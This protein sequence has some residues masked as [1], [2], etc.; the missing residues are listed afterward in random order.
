MSVGHLVIFRYLSRE[1][2]VISAA[3]TA[4]LLLIFVS[5]RLIRFLEEAVGGTVTPDLIGA[6]ILYRLPSAIELIVPLAL[7]LGILLTLSR[8]QHDSELVVLQTSG[9]S[10]RHLVGSLSVFAGGIALVLAILSNFVFPALVGALDQRLAKQ[11]RLNAFDTAVPGRFET[12]INGR[13]LY[14]E[15]RSNDGQRLENVF[16]SEPQKDTEGER[17]TRASFAVVERRDE[18]EF[19]VLIDGFRYVGS[20]HRDDWEITRFDRYLIQIETSTQDSGPSLHALPTLALLRD[21]SNAALALVNWRISMPI[22]IFTMMPLAL[23]VGQSAPRRNRILWIIPIILAEFFYFIALSNGQKA[24]ERGLWS[25]FPGLLSIHVL[26]LIGALSLYWI[27]QI[28]RLRGR[29][30]F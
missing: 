3:V 20:P 28:K 4:V 19:L 10:T 21:G 15:S 1:I 12:D 24:I 29:Q 5:S 8:M 30:L 23:L 14:A 27:M 9:Y 6:M 16:I 25:P 26:V 7:T 11:D 17:F 22:L 13:S 18:G 2:A